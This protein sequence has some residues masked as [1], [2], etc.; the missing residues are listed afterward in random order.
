MDRSTPL[1]LCSVG[2]G[3]VDDHPVVV[4]DHPVAVCCQL[5]AGAALPCSAT[6][7]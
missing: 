2:V 4:D 3:V 6:G 5:V 7:P 1:L